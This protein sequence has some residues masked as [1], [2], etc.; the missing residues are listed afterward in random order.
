MC[1]SKDKNMILETL[2]ESNWGYIIYIEMAKNK[3]FGRERFISS[4]IVKWEFMFMWYQ[5][6]ELS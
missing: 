5:P 4:F 1:M 3:N 6:R 2:R